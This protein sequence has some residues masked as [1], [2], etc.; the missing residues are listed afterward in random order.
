MPDAGSRRSAYFAWI[1]VCIL[2]GTSY[3]GIRIALETI[4]PFLLTSARWT[5]AGAIILGILKL[6]GEQLPGPRHW[7][8]LTLLGVLLLG[9]GNGWVVWAEQTITSGLTAVLVAAAP[10]WMVAVE[11]AMPGGERLT[12]RRVGGLLVGFAGIVLLVWPELQLGAGRDFLL[13]VGATQ[14]ACLGWSIG[15]S[16]ARRRKAEE[17][18]LAA[19]GL[20]MLLGGLCV[21]PVALFHGELGHLAF[22]SRSVTAFVYLIF[23]GSIGGFCAYVYALKHL[24]VSTVSQYAY[25]NPVIA[26][27]LG[28]LI[29]SEPLSPRLIAAGAIVLAG[30]MMVRRS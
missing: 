15:S 18:V 20:E 19:A 11:R 28:T 30:M 16:Y 8:A 1:A 5:I 21:L 24:P 7:P 2:W 27:L 22:S 12:I 9:F 29:L 6:R 10:F 13:A 3:L 25:V 17:N 14:L 23:F 4:P 26:V